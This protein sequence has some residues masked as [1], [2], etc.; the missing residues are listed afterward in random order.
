MKQTADLGG[1]NE[2]TLVEWESRYM[3]GIPPIDNQHRELIDLTNELYEACLT[4]DEEAKAIFKQSIHKVVDYINYHFSAEEKMLQNIKYPDFVPHKKEHES[5]VKRVL[6]DVHLFEQGRQ[7]VPN[8]FVRMLKE[9]ILTH[10]AMS[11][12]RYSEYIMNLK[13]QGKLGAA[14]ADA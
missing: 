4:G 9:W 5:L 10:I 13:K 11:D 14:L 6:E 8:S 12:K 1:D 3:M 2:K 7:F